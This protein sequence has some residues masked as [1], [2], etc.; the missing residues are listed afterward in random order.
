MKNKIKPESPENYEDANNVFDGRGRLLNP[1][2]TFHWH[3]IE[4]KIQVMNF[5]NEIKGRRRSFLFHS[6]NRVYDSL[7][8]AWEK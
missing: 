8:T 5:R 4:R 6:K 1:H 3:F 2:R 7:L